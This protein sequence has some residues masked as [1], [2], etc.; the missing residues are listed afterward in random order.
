MNKLV[1]RPCLKPEEIE[2][3]I[4]NWKNIMGDWCTVKTIGF[5]GGYP[6][7]MAIMTNPNIDDS[8]KE[9][10]VLVAQHTIEISGP[11]TIFSVG[12]YLSK[13]NEES[14]E[15][16]SKQKIILVPC[17][18]LYSYSKMDEAYQFKN[19][20]GICEYSAAFNKNLEVDKEIAP[21]AYALKEIIDE[22]KPE[23]LI[24]AHGLW[25]KYSGCMEV[26]GSYSFARLNACYDKSFV[27]QMNNAARKK[28]YAIVDEDYQQTIP[29]TNADVCAKPENFYKFRNGSPSIVLGAY[30]YIKYHTFNI[31]LEVTYEESGL[32]RIIEA[33]KLGCNPICATP[34]YGYPVRV[35]KSPMCTESIVC[36]GSNAKERR[37]S[38][39]ELWNQTDKLGYALFAPQLHGLQTIMISINH[40]KAYETFGHGGFFKVDNF[41][42]SLENAGYKTD[43]IRKIY[44]EVASQCHIEGTWNNVGDK[45][46]I[47]HGLNIRFALPFY[48]AKIE[49][50]ILNNEELKENDYIIFR[51]NNFTY[52]EV[53]CKGKLPDFMIATVKYSFEENSKRKFGIIR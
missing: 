29:P 44:G 1:Y 38:R 53:I 49:T 7:T 3:Y 16:L 20:A 46:D 10:A 8:K 14:V 26:T 18:N 37:E 22:Y 52:V 15:I 11:N 28:G 33:L 40:S 27:D 5:S 17:A 24:D 12:N 32:I 4:L 13:L 21:A 25:Y 42:D 31:N 41:L 48:D 47:K 51:H 34:N 36:S 30:A 2:G 35:L 6:I 43:K 19:E 39:V 45:A 50:I 9:V 23:L